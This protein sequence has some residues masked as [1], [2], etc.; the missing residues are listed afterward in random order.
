MAPRKHYLQVTESDFA[1]A[2]HSVQN[3][4][5]QPA[6]RTRSPKQEGVATP[7]GC[8]TLRDRAKSRDS[9]HL[10]KVEAKRFELSTLALRTPRSPN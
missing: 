2:V 1:K 5:R 4:V 8:D 9:K 7:C 6:A 3:P 10:A